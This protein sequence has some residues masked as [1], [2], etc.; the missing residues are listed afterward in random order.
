MAALI[1]A[2]VRVLYNH[3]GGRAAKTAAIAVT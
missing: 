3:D 2:R 1:W